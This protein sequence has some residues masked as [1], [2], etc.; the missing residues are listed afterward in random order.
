[1]W[2]Y[3]IIHTQSQLCYNACLRI[4]I[5]SIREQ[6]EHNANFAFPY[7]WFHVRAIL[8][9]C[10]KLHPDEPSWWWIHKMHTF[11]HLKHLPATWLHHTR[12]KL[13]SPTPSVTALSH[14]SDTSLPFHSNSQA[15][16]LVLTSAS[17]LQVSFKIKRH[18]LCSICVFI[19]HLRWGETVLLFWLG[20]YLFFL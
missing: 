15:I 3:N 6:I 4:W 8:C 12:P 2:N 20:S 19:G 11:T 18:N 14:V 10:R 7:A 16:G 13:H 17:E 9:D 5:C 1:M